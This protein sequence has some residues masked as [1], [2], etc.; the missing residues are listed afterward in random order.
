MNLG[1]HIARL[2]KEGFDIIPDLYSEQEVERICD[3]ISNA[4]LSDSSVISSD[5]LFAVRQVLTEIPEL[6]DLVFNQRLRELINALD[7]HAEYFLS[8]AIYFD[9]PSSSNW[10]VAY[11]QDLTINVT[12]KQEV[13]GFNNWTEK[14]GQLGVQPP[15]HILGRTVTVRIH[16]DDT[17][18]SNGALRVLPKSHLHGVVRMDGTLEVINEVTCEVQRGGVMLMKPLT[19]HASSR[20]VGNKNRR[21]LHLEFCDQEL[22]EPLTWKEKL[23]VL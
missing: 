21:V 14:R 18:G 5:E 4:S 8:K 9:K 12:E 1:A 7:S 11:H 23:C 15:L 10:F 2:N 19:L 6:R 17:D 3:I 16:L 20:S 22:P 13:T